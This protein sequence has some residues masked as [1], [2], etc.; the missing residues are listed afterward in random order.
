ML[1]AH[2]GQGLLTIASF[3]FLLCITRREQVAQIY[4]KPIYVIKDIAILPLSSQAEVDQAIGQNRAVTQGARK[5]QGA[6]TASSGS[7]ESEDDSFDSHSV[8]DPLESQSPMNNSLAAAGGTEKST[9]VV[10]DVIQRK[11]QYG[12][13]A[14]QW[15]SRR[16]WGLIDRRTEETSIE[17]VPKADPADQA[18]QPETAMPASELESSANSVARHPMASGKAVPAQSSSHEAA[19]DMLPKIIRTTKLLFTSKSFYFSYDFNITK[20]FGSSSIDALRSVSL[21]DME[22]QVS[23]TANCLQRPPIDGA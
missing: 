8:G 21:E 20:R 15:F 17:I 14:S 1:T 18:S 3:S 2:D 5:S 13:F 11:G 7:E 12:R 6:D 9:N 19:I 23:K 10:Q 22:Q 16:G 4:G